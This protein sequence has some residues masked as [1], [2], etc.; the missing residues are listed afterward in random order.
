MNP[1]KA[2]DECGQSVW[3]DFLSRRFVEDGSLKELIARD[4]LGGVTSNP[5]IFEKAIDAGED[6]AAAIVAAL[7]A[8]DRTPGDLYELL[9]IADIQNAA[10]V[11]RPVYDATGRRDGF[12]SLEVS[13]YL[14]L[15]TAATIAEARRLWH[16]V[17]RDNVMVKVPATPAGLP[18]IR[19]LLGEGININITLLFSQSVY[20]DVAEAFLAGAEAFAADGGELGRLASVASFFVS[21]ID[22]AV[23]KR[24]EARRDNALAILKG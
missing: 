20:A 21:R 9:A 5:A 18:A 12:V 7:K 23:D 2:L 10:D 1:L 3:L 17:R 11:L 4:G 24:I 8:T 13:P 6:Y 14:A 16:A 22:T 19:R 15:D